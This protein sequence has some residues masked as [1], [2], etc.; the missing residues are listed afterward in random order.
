MWST[1]ARA[2]AWLARCKVA[3]EHEVTGEWREVAGHN[4]IPGGFRA[5]CLEASA[6]RHN[7][8]TR[9][10]MVTILGVKASQAGETPA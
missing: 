2:T 10:T 5:A 7:L 4:E 3:S 8:S 6:V 1:L 9:C